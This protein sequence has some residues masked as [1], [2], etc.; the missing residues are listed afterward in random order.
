MGVHAAGPHTSTLRRLLALALVALCLGNAAALA[1]HDNPPSAIARTSSATTL[2]VVPPSIVATTPTTPPS[3]MKPQAA[4]SARKTSSTTVAAT[5][6]SVPQFPIMAEG[7]AYE[8]VLTPT[9]AKAG[10]VFTATLKLKPK[11]GSAGN[12]M[13]FYADNS[14]EPGTAQIAKPDGTVTYSWVAQPVPG[15]GR[16]VTQAQDADTHGFGTKI[17]AFRVVQGSESC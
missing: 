16:L 1:A 10:Q 17:V 11:W 8:V 2:T 3:V 14:H 6:E 5:A 13:P 4:A 7:Y 15:E 9:C 12:I